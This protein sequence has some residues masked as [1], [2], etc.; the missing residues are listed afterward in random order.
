MD[1]LNTITGAVAGRDSLKSRVAYYQGDHLQ[2]GAGWI[3][4]RAKDGA[5]IQDAAA[6]A[7]RKIFTSRNLIR[8]STI[9]HRDA[10]IGEEINWSFTT[11][12]T[13]GKD[14][15]PSAQEQALIDEA[16]GEI[17][18]WW[19][20]E[21]VHLSLQ[22]ATPALLYAALNAEETSSPLRFY[23]RNGELHFTEVSPL[24]AGVVRDLDGAPLFGFYR[25]PGEN[26]LSEI[27]LS[28]L[29]R[30]VTPKLLELLTSYGASSLL[31]ANGQPLRPALRYRDD[32]TL[33]IILS[34]GGVIG[35]AAYP[36][37][38]LLT[39]YDM[40]REPLITENCLEIQRAYNMTQTMMVENV[41]TSGFLERILLN[42]ELPGRWI[43]DGVEVEKGTLGATY[44]PEPVTVGG[45]T[46]NAFQG[47]EYMDENGGIKRANP[48]VVFREP[49][50][51]NTFKDVLGLLEST[52]YDE[53]SQL[54]VTLSD[55]QASGFKLV[56]ATNDFV[57]SLAVTASE[58][59]YATT[60]L[61][62]VAMRFKAF[63]AGRPG[64]YEAI[65]PMASAIISAVQPTA[66]DIRLAMEGIGKLWDTTEAIRRAGYD[67]PEA[68]AA[69][70]LGEGEPV[71][72]EEEAVSAIAE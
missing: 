4:P 34:E 21:R 22:K 67:E 24:Q 61:L 30:D 59:E 57:A 19:V 25:Y 35:A 39:I 5:T 69:R 9:R 37:G 45:G 66:D 13:L 2:D 44:I 60:W 33:V 54:F 17:V 7:I 70:V 32:D 10:V 29:G 26:G 6:S 49:V 36:L 12:R 47:V 56:Q 53:V 31:G 20:T 14:E 42:V 28:V 52:F 18:P 41:I 46:L 23:F 65:R 16:T 38:G 3:G 15:K 58:L 62:T 51:V 71:E 55:A 40:R 50:P 11:A 48:Q 72:E 68:M 64:K 1:I 27:E 43:K 8:K 63:L